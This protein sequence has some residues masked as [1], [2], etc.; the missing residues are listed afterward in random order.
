MFEVEPYLRK[1]GISPKDIVITVPDISPNISLAAM[2]NPG[3]TASRDNPKDVHEL[4][5][6]GASYLIINDST[7]AN[8]PLYKPYTT[9]LAGQYKNI[10][11]YDIRLHD[12]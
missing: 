4:Q 8:D 5:K 7:Y 6:Q 11:I 12:N 9:K 2:N 1:I 10:Y 3:Y